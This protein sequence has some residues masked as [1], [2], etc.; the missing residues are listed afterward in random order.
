M[1]YKLTIDDANAI[2]LVRVYGATTHEEH[3]AARKE[4]AQICRNK[5]YRRLLV[6]LR[7]LETEHVVSTKTCFEFAM[8][9][10]QSGLP[11]G[12]RIAHLMP[13][14]PSAHENVDFITTI[15]KHR[16]A[17]IQNFD[18]LDEAKKWLLE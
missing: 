14:S 8:S 2:I 5:E 12:L 6:D 3:Q 4:T 16:S 7:D 13:H 17:L 18:D 1:P 11:D 10:Q 9:Y 15:A